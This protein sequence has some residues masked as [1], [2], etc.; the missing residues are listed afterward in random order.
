ML[1]II[2]TAVVTLVVAVPVSLAIANASYQKASAK[3][4]GSAEDRAREIIDE[5]VKNAETKKR[6]GSFRGQGRVYEYQE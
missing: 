4:V 5:A 6:E 2:I 3:K 1:T